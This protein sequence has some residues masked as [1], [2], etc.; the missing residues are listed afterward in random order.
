MS[1]YS[2]AQYI[3]TGDSEESLMVKKEATPKFTDG[4][5]RDVVIPLNETITPDTVYF[6]KFAIQEDKVYDTTYKIKLVTDGTLD[7]TDNH[8]TIHTF[9]VFAD[10]E[11]GDIDSSRVCLYVNP[12][13]GVTEVA[14]PAL[15][16]THRRPYHSE[17]PYLW[18]YID[19]KNNTEVY[20]YGDKFVDKYN[21]IVM[22]HNW[23]HGTENEN[24]YYFSGI[25]SSRYFNS[26]FNTILIEIVRET[27]DDEL[28]YKQGTKTYYGRCINLDKLDFEIYEIK[29]QIPQE[30]QII[31]KIG[32]QGP[33]NM[34]MVINGEEIKIGPSGVFELDN[35]D[36]RSFGA[37]ATKERFIVDYQ[38]TEEEGS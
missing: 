23:H 28:I 2:M 16:E 17:T 29:K 36:I 37:C 33:P 4:R 34:S 7:N 20:Y 31:K 1:L 27:L 9:T 38:Y 10:K 35:F 5:Y 13:T 8:E 18:Y 15:S 24:M 19:Q 6:V 32:V 30:G 21:D 26:N 3:Y 25:V 12:N 14:I 22:L 11:N